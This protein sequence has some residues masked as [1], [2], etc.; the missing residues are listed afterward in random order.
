MTRIITSALAKWPRE[1]GGQALIIVLLLLM[2][3]S[4]TLPPILSYLSTSLKSGEIYRSR[5]NELYAADS[6]IEDAIWQIKYDRLPVLFDSPEYDAYDYTTVW[7]YDLTDQINGLTANVTVRNVWIPK[8]V[9]PLSPAESK[10]M[11]DAEKLI[12]TGTATTDS[13]Y[14]IKIDFFPGA[15]EENALQIVSLGV[16]LP[17]GFTY[18][19]GSSNLEEDPFE[20]SYSVPTVSAH[21]GGQAIVW[22][23]NPAVSYTD[24][25]GVSMVDVPMSTEIIFDYSAAQAGERPVAISW[26]ETGGVSDVPLAW[27]IDTK[28]YKVVS[29]AG[30][31]Q[32]E[33]Y[34]SRAELRKMS[35]AI[36]GD[37]RA[38]GN[39]LMLD[40]YSP[41]D[42]RDTLISSSSAEVTDIPA[43]ADVIAAYL[44]WSGWFSSG[45]T[46][47]IGPTWP[48][49]GANFNNWTNTSPN[50]VWQISSG[51]FRGH[52][53]TGNDPNARYLAMTASMNL[54]SYSPGSIVVEWDQQGT[55]SLEGADGLQFQFS[56][57]GGSSWGPLLTAFMDDTSSEYFHYVVPDAYLT[58]QFKMRFYLADMNGSSEYAYIDNFAVAQITG[59][60]DT[61][62]R[63]W[64]NGQQVYLDGDG[65]PQQGAQD[66]TAS[67]APV[68]GNKNRGNYSYAGFLDVTKLVKAYSDLGSNNNHTGNGEYAVG[69]VQANTGDYWSYAGWSLI[70]IF[71]S[72]ETAGHQLY[73]YDTFAFSGGDQNLDFDFDGQPG[74]TITGFVIPE[75]IQGETDAAKLTI[76]IGEGDSIYTGDYLIFKGTSLSDGFSTNNV[77]NGR[78]VGMTYDGVDIDTFH[79]TWASGLLQ[80]DDIQAQIDMPSA[81]DNWNLVYMILSLRSE[82]VTG[83][84]RHYVIYSR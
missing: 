2:F 82:T 57:D 39:S 67:R 80:A 41:F 54:S 49:T 42:K 14:R 27:D 32:I 35:A 25:P 43:D 65:Q 81:T 31:T 8:D 53:N 47:A 61:G 58:G 17:L 72:P 62:A 51:R 34:P 40:N 52:F 70:V 45:Y 6:G 33:A 71:S 60:A 76:F 28:I 5:T 36:A 24:F 37:Y 69:D 63:F 30:V 16:W 83:G 66:I 38:V 22:E 56:A 21:A 1:Q 78:S 11:I 55:S 50:T 10:A 13:N 9:A 15:G 73:L 4:L 29:T 26:L 68:L 75:P 64:I 23:F 20:E 46:S 7:S 3:G 79:I 59:T 84:T 12:L 74:G 18:A 48:D 44:Y 77:W 19:V